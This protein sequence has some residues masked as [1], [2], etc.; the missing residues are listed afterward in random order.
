MT[1]IK[2]LILEENFVNFRHKQESMNRIVYD[3]MLEHNKQEQLFSYS[4]GMFKV[5]IRDGAYGWVNLYHHDNEN[6]YIG[7]DTSLA[8]QLLEYLT[9]EVPC[10]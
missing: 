6:N 2:S 7:T 10:R 1:K 5:T 4:D 3:T 8:M 9:S